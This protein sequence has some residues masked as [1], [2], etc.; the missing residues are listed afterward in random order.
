MG[1]T[2]I[3]DKIVLMWEGAYASQY[4][5]QVSDDGSSWT[6]VH[7]HN[8]ASPIGDHTDEIALDQPA[9]GRY[10]RMQGV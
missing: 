9:E 7:T 1:Q 10:V 6:D 5:I 4:K 8:D 3:I 2:D